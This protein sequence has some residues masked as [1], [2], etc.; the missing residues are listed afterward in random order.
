MEHYE[1]DGLDSVTSLTNTSGAISGTYSY[2]GFGKLIASTGSTVNPQ[3][4][5]APESDSE[6][7]LYY[8]RTRYFEPGVRRFLGEDPIGGLN[9]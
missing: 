3:Q 6:T 1:A 5:T 4:F 7:G 9:L 8:Y 2:D